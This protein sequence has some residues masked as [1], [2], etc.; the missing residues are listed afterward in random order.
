MA[1]PTIRGI[2]LRL[3]L[4]LVLVVAG[5]LGVVY[6]IVVPSLES[7]LVNAK[8][9]QLEE[10]A[11]TVATGFAPESEHAQEYAEFRSSVVQARIVIYTV[12]ADTLFIQADSNTTSSLDVARDP[13]AIQAALTGKPQR[14]TLE[15]E[16]RDFAEGAVVAAEWLRGKQGFFEFKDVLAGK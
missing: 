7:E 5:A 3:A 16:G 6:L 15:R 9:D 13:I 12:V 4:A 14:G 8:V 11:K 2:R 10:D 1:R